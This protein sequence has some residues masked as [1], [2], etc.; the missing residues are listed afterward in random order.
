MPSVLNTSKPQIDALTGIRILAAGYVFLFHIHIFMVKPLFPEI[1][2]IS[3]MLFQGGWLGVDLFFLLSGFIISYNYYEA[4]ASEHEDSNYRDF[5]FKRFAR[6]YPVHFFT[7]MAVFLPILLVFGSSIW[8]S[9]ESLRPHLDHIDLTLGSL[10]KNLFLINGWILPSLPSIG[11][12][13]AVSWSV[14]CEWLAYLCFP[15]VVA[16][17]RPIKTAKQAIICIAFICVLALLVAGITLSLGDIGTKVMGLVRISSEFT[18]GAILYRLFKFKPVIDKPKTRLFSLTVGVVTIA[19]FCSGWHLLA[20]AWTIPF[21]AWIILAIARGRVAP[22]FLSSRA[23]IYGGKISY[24]LYLCHGV[25][26]VLAMMFFD[27]MTFV[28]AA[29]STKVVYILSYMSASI[30]LTLFSFHFV[31]EPSR[32]KLVTWWKANGWHKPKVVSTVARSN[33]VQ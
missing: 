13:N 16:M 17:I 27:P 30:A 18:V 28:D 23:F 7:T 22:P 15:L 14:S 20:V 19:V 33:E 11:G 24:S 10:F 29:T 31:E 8:A 6:I 26:L 25:C 2:L 3:T 4:F 12:W 21:Y 5:L 32:K 1:A 9:D